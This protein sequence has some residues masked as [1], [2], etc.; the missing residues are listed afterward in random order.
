VTLVG[1][2]TAVDPHSF[3]VEGVERVSLLQ[4]PVPSALDEADR[5]AADEVIASRL[6]ELLDRLG[7]GSII[8]TQVWCKEMLDRIPHDEWQVIG[9]YHSSAEAAER[10]G[11]AERLVASYADAD[12]V[13]ALT[14]ADADA[15][16]GWGLRGTLA[17]PNPV[18]FW[19][20]Q[21]SPLTDRVVTY[22]GRISLE[23][24]PGILAEAWQRVAPEHQDWRMRFIG[25]G[26]LEDDLRS[27]GLPRTEFIEPTQ[28]PM[29]FL[30]RSSVLALPSLVEGFPLA[31]LEAMACGLP[32]VAADASAGV[33]ELLTDEATG[34]LVVRGDVGHFAE[35]LD[36][37]L[38]DEELRRRMGERARQAAEAY[39]LDPILDRWE[40]LLRSS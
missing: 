9:Q 2:E 15:F 38:S 14:Q 13:V 30:L 33:R 16:A 39:R 12:L 18:A 32:A 34:L 10:S 6:R 26:P 28:N 36:R 4:T 24:A 17:L 11:D 20:E 35:Q 7:A 8:T 23:K 3:E 37:L 29:G 27:M 25:S 21:P 31:L 40:S 22:L 19:P 5:A 1:L